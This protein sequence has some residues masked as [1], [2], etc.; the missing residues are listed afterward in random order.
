MFKPKQMLFKNA[1]EPGGFRINS[2]IILEEK[3]LVQQ[4][5]DPRLFERCSSSLYMYVRGRLLCRYYSVFHR[6][7]FPLINTTYEKEK[8]L[9][10]QFLGIHFS[11][12]FGVSSSLRT[13]I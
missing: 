5:P 4:H 12:A 9:F 6:Q 7:T 10:P 1:S 2:A 8:K 3:A 13:N 11:P